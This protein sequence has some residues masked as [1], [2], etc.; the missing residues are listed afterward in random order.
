MV[1]FIPLRLCTYVITLHGIVLV[2]KNSYYIHQFFER[3]L[4]KIKKILDWLLN[5]VGITRSYV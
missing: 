2:L 4:R 5:G 3:A 1:F